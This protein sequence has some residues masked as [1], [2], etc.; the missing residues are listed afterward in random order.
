[1][2]QPVP[3]I[4][5]TKPVVQPRPAKPVQRKNPEPQQKTKQAQRPKNNPPAQTGSKI[6]ITA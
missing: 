4:A 2:P 3:G 5:G 1:M 6:N